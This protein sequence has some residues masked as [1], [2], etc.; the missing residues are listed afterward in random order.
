MLCAFIWTVRLKKFVLPDQSEELVIN[1]LPCVQ[2]LI[3]MYQI[4][5]EIN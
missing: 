3:Y 1:P 5:S 2:G 4:Q